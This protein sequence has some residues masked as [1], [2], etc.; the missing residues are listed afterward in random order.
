[1]ASEILAEMTDGRYTTLEVNE[2]YE[3][4][5]RDDGEPKPIISGGE[6]DIVNLSLRLAV[7][8]MIADRAGQDLSVLVLDEVFGSLDDIRRDNVIALLQALKSRFE[9]I[10]LITHIESVHDAVDNCIWID[11]DEG[12]KTS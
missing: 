2:D 3:A 11:Y 7:S 1:I 9:Q 8:R 4:T 10:I 5:I 6:E 12:T